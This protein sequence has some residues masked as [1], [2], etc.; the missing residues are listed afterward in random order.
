MESNPFDSAKAVSIEQ[1]PTTDVSGRWIIE[2][3]VS[4]AN[5]SKYIGMKIK[6]RL[7]LDQD[8]NTIEGNAVKYMVDGDSIPE[9]QQIK[10]DLNGK[11]IGDSIMLDFY[12]KGKP[13]KFSWK[14]NPHRKSLDG[15]FKSSVAISRGDS[16]AHRRY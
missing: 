12:E 4:S 8:K 1:P 7:F 11:I 10:L 5:D 15:Y 13:G 14:Y 9:D 16:H 3:T 2:N 6:F